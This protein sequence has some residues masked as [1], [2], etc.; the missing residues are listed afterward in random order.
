MS[1]ASL[2]L[3]LVVGWFGQSA[4]WVWALARA[5]RRAATPLEWAPELLL[6]AAM[7]ALVVWALVGTAGTRVPLPDGVMAACVVLFLTGHAVAVLG[8]VRL[9]GAWGIGTRP[10][11]DLDAPV[12]SG[13]YRLVAHPIYLGTTTAV[14]AQLAVLQN[15]PS[16]LLVAGAAAVNPWKIARERRLLRRAGLPT[17][18]GPPGH[19][20]LGHLPAFRQEPLGFLLR[21]VRDWGDVVALRIGRQ[22][23]YLLW[24][25]EHVQQV[26][27]TNQRIYS[28]RVDPLKR[29]SEVL[30]RGLVTSTGDLW[31]RQRRLVQ[32]AFHPEALDALGPVITRAIAELVDG[33]RPLARA[34]AVLDVHHEMMRL[35]FCIVGETLFGADLRQQ[36][37]SVRGALA[38]VQQQT[39]ERLDTLVPLP[40]WV[41]TRRNRAF[42]NALATLDRVVGGVIDARTAAGNGAGRADLLATLMAARDEHTGRPIGRRQLRDEIVTLLLAGHENT[43][44]ALTWLWYLI[45]RHPPVADRVGEELGRVLHGRPPAWADLPALPYARMVIEETLRLYPTSWLMLRRA[46]EPDEIG[47][48]AI[49]RGA[50]IVISPYLTHRHPEHWS[51]PEVFDPERFE[52]QRSSARHRFAYFPFG[53][54]PRKCV[55]S[56]FAAGE[57]QLV[58]AA[59]A[60]HYCFELEAGQVAHPLP[61]VSLPPRGGLPLRMRLRSGRD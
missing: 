3:L 30:G 40:L 10:R 41:P 47:G 44:N 58:L 21:A 13:I 2:E 57:L 23:A 24:R 38:V 59:V 46:E 56:G 16:L 17:A 45:A 6:R 49:E 34:G 55:G 42:H 51:D 5:G 14:V 4:N 37:D 43:G 1:H 35:T 7:A 32:P 8:R 28:K 20:L 19:M 36:A 26:L 12:R 9:G 27:Q 52:E 54:G 22:P 11:A 39:N 53:G 18:P 15:L 25:P 60:Q 48:F 33:W 50:I 31:R 29:L 61:V